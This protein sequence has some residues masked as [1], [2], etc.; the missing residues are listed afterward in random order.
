MRRRWS[1][2][3]LKTTFNVVT[4][5]GSLSDPCGILGSLWVPTDPE[6]VQGFVRIP[7][8][9]CKNPET[10]SDSGRILRDSLG[11]LKEV[12]RNPETGRNPTLFLRILQEII[13]IPARYL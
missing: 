2:V 7:R 4:A 11:F 9:F 1:S 6:T 3:F 10:G 12:F 13:G 5:Q 8:K